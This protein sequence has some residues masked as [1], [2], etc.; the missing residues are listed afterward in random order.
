MQSINGPDAI[1]QYLFNQER[2]QL[3]QPQLV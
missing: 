3:T 2:F 1:N